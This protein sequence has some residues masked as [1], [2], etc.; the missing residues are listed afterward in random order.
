MVSF[1]GFVRGLLI[2]AMA[3][4]LARGGT[5]LIPF[6][7]LAVAE[8]LARDIDLVGY[9][10]HDGTVTL[11]VTKD[12]VRQAGI[13]NVVAYRELLRSMA[14]VGLDVHVRLE[15][16]PFHP[17]YGYDGPPLIASTRG[18]SS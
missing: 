1:D 15:W 18:R 4:S 7:H 13:L 10:Y 11:R 3:A 6:K 14:P 16:K 17:D 8:A 9:E 2:S 12:S 5:G